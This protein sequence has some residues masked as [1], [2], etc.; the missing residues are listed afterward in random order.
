VLFILIVAGCR[1]SP[2]ASASIRRHV[3]VLLAVN[4][5]LLVIVT[6][7]FSKKDRVAPLLFVYHRH[8]ATGVLLLQDNQTFSVPE[9]Y[10]ASRV[11]RC[12]G[13]TG[14]G[15]G[16]CGEGSTDQL[17]DRLQRHAGRRSRDLA[18]HYTAISQSSPSSSR[19]SR[20]AG[21]CDQSTPQQSPYGCDLH[22]FVV[23]KLERPARP[24]AASIE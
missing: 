4:T 7:S 14:T 22:E 24:S 9:Y 8:D 23:A 5:A 1:G 19:V 12:R 17:R 21:T 2:G 15:R 20:T 18:E 11:Q 10:L 3:V 6:F 13:G 16:E